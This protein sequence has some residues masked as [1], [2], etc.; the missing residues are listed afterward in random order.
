MTVYVVVSVRDRAVDAFGRP[1]FVAAVGAAIRS[2]QDEL[3]REHGDN[4]MWLHPDD[5]DLYELGSWDDHNGVMLQ[6][7]RPRQIAVG[8]QLAVRKSV[9]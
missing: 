5:F 2:F 7:E 6:L 3:N 1:A 8:K 9:K 4:Q